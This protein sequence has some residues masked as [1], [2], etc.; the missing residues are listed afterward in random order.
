MRFNRIN[1]TCLIELM[2]S[3]GFSQAAPISWANGIV[4]GDEVVSND[5]SLIEACNFGNSSVSSPVI[6][7]VP[8]TGIDFASG[9]Q[10]VRLVGLSYN[11]GENGKLPG[12]GVN[13][14]SDTIAY[15]SGVDPQSATLTG[16]SI[17]RNYEVQ[18][19][20][21]HNTVDRS[22]TISDESNGRITLSEVGEPVYATGLFTAD[23]TT[24]PITFDANIGSQFL[25]AYQIREV[26]PVAPLI[27]NEVIISEFMASN[28][29]SLD[30]GDGSSS[31][32][33]EIWNSTT[34]SVDLA[35]WSLT[36]S[37]S[38]TERW[39]FPSV[40][41]AP[42][43]FLIVFASGQEIE[44][45][46]D[47]AGNLHTNFS[48]NHR[49][50]HLPSTDP[51]GGA[52]F[53]IASEYSDYPPQ[54]T[55]VSYGFFGDEVPLGIG[56]LERSTPASTNS[57]QGYAGFVGDTSFHPNRG[58]YDDP[59][60]VSIETEQPDAM[61]RY[62]LDGS[63]PS[64]TNGEDY[65]GGL[66]IPVT[67]T[68]TLRAAAFKEGFQPSN[69][70]THTYLFVSD[71]VNQP[72]APPGFP[73]NWTGA[74]YG[75]EDHLPDLA[76]IAGDAGLN[77]EN[78]K[79]I[80]R[81]ALLELPALSLVMEVDDWF[82]AANGIY[83]NSTA[84]GAA[85][86]RACSA[87]FMSP[88][89]IGRAAF[90]IDCG[91]R[92]QGNT[93]RNATANP[94]H[95]LRLAFREKYGDSKLRYPF[96]GED[97]PSEFDTIVL[98][99]NSQDGWVYNTGRNRMGQ[100]VR[101]AWARETHRRMGHSS[102]DSNWIHL[103]ING[104]YWGVYNPTE[105]PDAAHGESHY[106]GDKENWD[107]IKNHEEVLDG[108]ITAY[109]ELLALIQKDPNNWNA[110]YRDLSAPD[111]YAAVREAIDVEMLI[112]Y[113]IH[114]M[115]AAADD[116]PGNFYMGYDR[117]GA[118]GGWKFY[119]WDNEHGMKNPVNLNRTLPH[120]RDDDSPT[121][122]HHALRSSP[123]YRQL[124][125]D[126]LHRA[127]F[128]GGVLYVDLGNTEWDPLHP[129]RNVPAALWMA[130]T[131]E[132]ETALIAESARWGD[133]R[134]TIPYTVANEFESL[135]N[136][137]LS[138]W[139]PGRSAVVL[140]QF[141]A[142][143]LYPDVAAPT[144]SQFGG[145]VENGFLLGMV[146]PESGAIYYTIN[147]E[148]PGVPSDNEMEMIL[149]A[150][151]GGGQVLI[152]S[153]DPGEEWKNVGYDDGSWLSGAGGIG[154]ETIPA[155]YDS[156]IGF[157]VME[158][159]GKSASVFLRKSFEIA[160]EEALAA[161]GSLILKMRYDD[162]FV[163]YLNGV[164]VAAANDPE[165]RNWQSGATASHSDS[166]AVNALTF[167]ITGDL[168]QLRIGENILAIHGLNLG[169]NSSDFL[170]SPQLVA[171]SSTLVGISPSARRYSGEVALEN[172]GV[173]RAR[174]LDGGEWSALTEA[175]F[176]VGTPATAENLVISEIMYHAEAGKQHDYLELMNVSETETLQLSGVKFR[177]GIEYE[178]PLGSTL[179]PG[180]R[181]L[182]VEDLVAFEEHYETE[183]SV[184]GQYS[185]KLDNGGERLVLLE[186]DG[187]LLR[188]F[189]YDDEG[190]WPASA[191]GGGHS[192]VLIA[193]RTLPS[194]DD[195]G[196]WRPS[197]LTGGS[198][199]GSD[200][201]QFTGDA[202]E[203]QDGDT[204]P[205]LLEYALGSSDLVFDRSVLPAEGAVGTDVVFSYTR[206]LAADDVVYHVE[207]SNDL[208]S[209][210]RVA[211]TLGAVSRLNQGDG[212]QLIAFRKNPADVT[213]KF[214]RL[215]VSL[216]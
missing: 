138:H 172:S 47:L 107:A 71:V 202:E 46:L 158:M 198:P 81:D 19:F 117:S 10:P 17:G 214:W 61:I 59:I 74:D 149:L 145:A 154:Y 119:D 89:V 135:R 163:A 45:H 113:M 15:R 33:I 67:T 176:V 92:V 69:I 128:N 215:R 184:F 37:I 28:E 112:D 168:D 103:Y 102:P 8:F 83:A 75:M 206:N 129:E 211:D 13:E 106:G 98:R 63:E 42:N 137:L 105:R 58:F 52:G 166:L 95:S 104:L 76:L 159:F 212:L 11:T 1:L 189:S 179:L 133:Y 2:V 80:I 96:F 99:S 203:D 94:K 65:P 53:E 148:D 16:L 150:E 140:G 183:H 193:P 187:S 84:R 188:D 141:Q 143:G 54:K 167:D 146:E 156:L 185:G 20:Y 177:E 125:A 127:F 139:F 174:V 110:G 100:F 152:P 197:V 50:G 121:K 25:N 182:L 136:D 64:P 181:I 165:V 44:N 12:Q 213:G 201:T 216:R 93:S 195:P 164:E 132:I 196:S 36:T 199:G 14:L 144:L 118:S 209:W 40:V 210:I 26:M 22:V 126:R 207:T 194:H 60:M 9:E 208:K 120:G 122:F 157:S 77:V 124:F 178:F 111:D 147:G 70:D 91:V 23:A 86:E 78:S 48:P 180:E 205:G 131:S 85:W 55:D 115:Y 73:L 175:T 204:I 171:G 72:S 29:D 200:A 186:R 38:K 116:W 79:A 21:Y 142:Q 173:I 151:G 123:E 30:D 191:D 87:E 57:S 153:E 82:G 90:Q 162:G 5:G 62:T 31:D 68:T 108:N 39:T 170:I 155:D 51:G 56:Y 41:L 4:S 160:D 169:A 6:N 190:G 161:I 35:G 66:G 34:E 27:L 32:W 130:L 7:G 49:G 24:Q 97:S 134:K 88:E 114:N 43:E 101:D 109:R 3:A 192:L 18:F